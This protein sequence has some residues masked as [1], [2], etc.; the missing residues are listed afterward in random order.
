MIALALRSA[1]NA[2]LALNVGNELP[3][4]EITVADFAVSGVHV[5]AGLG[6]RSDDQEIANLVLLSQVFDQVPSAGFEKGLLVLAQAVQEIKHRIRMAF[7]AAE[8]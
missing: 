1:A 3:Q 8:S 7:A 5:E 6:F 4:K 2:V